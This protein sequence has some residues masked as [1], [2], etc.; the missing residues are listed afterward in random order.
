M[1]VWLKDA[2]INTGM[3]P[4]IFI[5]IRKGREPVIE[6]EV[7]ATID[8][9][10]GT[11]IKINLKNYENIYC[12]YFTISVVLVVIMSLFLQKV[13]QIFIKLILN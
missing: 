2:D 8:R 13:I 12:N 3:P 4:I 10:N 5:E 7:M 6:T 1:R 11:E 9:P